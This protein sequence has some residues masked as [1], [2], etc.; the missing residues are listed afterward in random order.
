MLDELNKPKRPKGRPP[1]SKNKEYLYD[2]P[3]TTHTHRLTPTAHAW[4]LKNK[5]RVENLAR[6]KE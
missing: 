3:T 6:G 2:E 4:V 5:Q 1:G